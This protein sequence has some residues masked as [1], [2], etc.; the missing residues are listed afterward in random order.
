MESYTPMRMGV[1][2]QG[3]AKNDYKP[4]IFVSNSSLAL[5][6]IS[7]LSPRKKSAVNC[8]L[9]TTEQSSSCRECI[10]A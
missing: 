9:L 1:F 8:N 3:P 5:V 10:R 7:I 6:G 2:R 4:G